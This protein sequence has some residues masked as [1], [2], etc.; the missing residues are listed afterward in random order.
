VAKRG[1]VQ[2]GTEDGG[3]GP[4]EEVHVG[5]NIAHF[6]EEE[7]KVGEVGGEDVGVWDG[8]WGHG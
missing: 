5:E 3:G 1:V 2:R 6:L 4:G 7:G 8:G